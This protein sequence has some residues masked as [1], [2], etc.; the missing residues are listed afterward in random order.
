MIVLHGLVS[1]LSEGGFSPEQVTHGSLS[2]GQRAADTDN[3][4]SKNIQDECVGVDFDSFTNW[5]AADLF[6]DLE[7]HNAE[8]ISSFSFRLLLISDVIAQVHFGK[9]PFYAILN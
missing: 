5:K 9:H 1:Y 3:G 6:E 8:N 7:L 2:G 4:Q